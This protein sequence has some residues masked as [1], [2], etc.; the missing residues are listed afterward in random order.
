M[1]HDYERQKKFILECLGTAG[2]RDVFM[3]E[4]SKD[5]PLRWDGYKI[6]EFFNYGEKEFDTVKFLALK[7]NH[8]ARTLS[9]PRNP[10]YVAALYFWLYRRCVKSGGMQCFP[11]SPLDEQLQSANQNNYEDEKTWT[12][13]WT[14]FY[15]MYLDS[16]TWH[17]PDEF[18]LAPFEKNTE[19][20]PRAKYIYEEVC[21]QLCGVRTSSA[22]V[23]H[24]R[25]G[26]EDEF[27]YICSHCMKKYW[28]DQ[29]DKTEKNPA[30]VLALSF[31]ANGFASFKTKSNHEP[32]A[33]AK[34]AE[35]LFNIVN[36]ATNY[37]VFVPEADWEARALFFILAQW[38]FLSNSRTA[39]PTLEEHIFAILYLRFYR[40][41][42]DEYFKRES[43]SAIW[44]SIP[45]DKKEDIAVRYRRLLAG[46]RNKAAASWPNAKVSDCPEI[47]DD[48]IAIGMV[49]Q[50][51]VRNEQYEKLVILLKGQANLIGHY[52]GRE[53]LWA[54]S[55]SRKIYSYLQQYQPH[56]ECY[57]EK[58]CVGWNY[59]MITDGW[60]RMSLDDLAWS[61]SAIRQ[62]L[63]PETY[64][65]LIG[66]A[67]LCMFDDVMPYNK[68]VRLSRL[69]AY[70]E[71]LK[72][73]PNVGDDSEHAYNASLPILYRLVEHHYYRGASKAISY[74]LSNGANPNCGGHRCTC[75][76][77]AIAGNNL[78]LVKMLLDAGADVNLSS[79]TDRSPVEVAIDHK[80]VKALEMLIK[81]GAKPIPNVTM[82]SEAF[83]L[84]QSRAIREFLGIA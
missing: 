44:D 31:Y 27:K 78:R 11:E 42:T 14:L 68:P 52:W 84:K 58:D 76:G 80:R 28:S 82:A 8:V 45:Y 53:M 21:R 17:F 63:H 37:R 51:L 40:Q 36:H 26:T 62:M 55:H 22:R 47:E 6:A 66:F 77:L 20:V 79:T 4:V 2:F 67:S 61:C 9:F 16:L 54:A 50:E 81:A 25:T 57:S 19:P 74:L 1:S 60:S 69:Q 70:I 72:L 29:F 75:L 18:K 24:D 65:S 83:W 30:L 38:L 13:Q 33:E 56:P 43:V 32:D 12:G 73:N 71:T 34:N 35:C 48:G 49:F 7:F 46:T 64:Q 39:E 41:G 23:F 5:R 3:Q 15:L 10:I 59:S